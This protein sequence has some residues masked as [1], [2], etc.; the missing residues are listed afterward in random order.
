MVKLAE[1]EGDINELS[2]TEGN[3]EARLKIAGDIEAIKNYKR[4]IT[5]T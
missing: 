2:E 4:H 3:I 5:T 1:L